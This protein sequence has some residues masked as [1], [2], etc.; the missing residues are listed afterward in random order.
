MPTSDGT[1]TLEEKTLCSSW[2]MRLAGRPARAVGLSKL[3]VLWAP[4]LGVLLQEAFPRAAP[5]LGKQLWF[6]HQGHLRR[7]RGA[8]SWAPGH[9]PE[10]T[11]VSAPFRVCDWL[12]RGAST[13]FTLWAT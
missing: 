9:L 5:T 10:E 2:K 12:T 7:R 13:L 6:S 3:Y 1:A 4:R 8:A 11:L